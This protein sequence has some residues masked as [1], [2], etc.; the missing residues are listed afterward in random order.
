MSTDSMD[1]HCSFVSRIV[2]RVL[3][4]CVVLSLEMLL[5][6]FHFVKPALVEEHRVANNQKEQMLP[7]KLLKSSLSLSSS[8]S[9]CVGI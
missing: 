8:S 3:I 5:S 6:K 4:Q 2:D 9:A 7:R 1:E